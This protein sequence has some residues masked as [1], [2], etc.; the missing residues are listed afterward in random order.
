MSYDCFCF[1]DRHFGRRQI[2]PVAL[3][4]LFDNRAPVVVMAAFTGGTK[5]AELSKAEY[6][7]RY[8]SAGDDVKASKGKVKKK[9][10]KVPVRG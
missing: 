4:V 1:R 6:L 2:D 9:R 10:I 7:K 3:S 5:S 8:L